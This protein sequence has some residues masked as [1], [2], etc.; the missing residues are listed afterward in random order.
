MLKIFGIML[1]IL[2]T[3]GIG[4]KLS[5]N[6]KYRI[7]ELEELK[8]F[9][10]ML[11]GEIMYNVASVSEGMKRIKSRLRTPYTHLIDKVLDELSEHNGKSFSEIWKLGVAVFEETNNS[12]TKSD[13]DRLRG[14]GDDFG[15]PHKE[16]QL[17]S[18]DMY[19]D[20]LEITINDA[21][22]KNS[23]NSKMYKSLGVLAGI[24]IVIL[25]V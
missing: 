15:S 5:D 24:V 7:E 20:E 16:I 25:I 13:V 12:L 6:L 18:F 10:I 8:K 9:M 3:S 1:V 19:I 21:R 14:F 2:S 22:K 4:I 11:R 17:K 23:D